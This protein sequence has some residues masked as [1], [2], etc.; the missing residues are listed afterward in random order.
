[1]R[2]AAKHAG[3]ARGALVFVVLEEELVLR[4]VE[5]SGSPKEFDRAALADALRGAP[6]LR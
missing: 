2:A 6:S 1:M 4:G 5:T 3:H